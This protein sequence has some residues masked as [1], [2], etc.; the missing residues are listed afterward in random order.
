MP[1]AGPPFSMDVVR[2]LLDL[3]HAHIGVV[4]SAMHER[5]GWENFLVVVSST[6]HVLWTFYRPRCRLDDCLTSRAYVYV[7]HDHGD[8]HHSYRET[9]LVQI[10]ITDG[11]VVT[12]IPVNGVLL[13]RQNARLN[14]WLKA[15]P[16]HTVDLRAVDGVGYVD[17]HAE[18][19]NLP[20][21]RLS[22]SQI[23]SSR[24]EAPDA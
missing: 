11:S 6:G 10:S 1:H 23:L 14:A 20:K 19:S 21:F 9:V 16:T 15:S 7:L 17:L 8:W 22:L 5:G 3:P 4:Q 12:E 13:R 2:H 24:D 18:Q